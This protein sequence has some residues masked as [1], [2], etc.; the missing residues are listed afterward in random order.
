[1]SRLMS[2]RYTLEIKPFFF[3]KSTFVQQDASTVAN[4]I[5]DRIGTVDF[6]IF[7]SEYCWDV[8]FNF[9]IRNIALETNFNDLVSYY[10]EAEA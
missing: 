2:A 7:F 4:K 10:Q 1:M 9:V 3:F 5:D 8:G 6:R